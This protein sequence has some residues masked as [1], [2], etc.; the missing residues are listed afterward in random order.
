L[1]SRLLGRLV[2]V[3]HPA[4]IAAVGALFALSFDTV[5]Q[6]ALFSLAARSLSGWGFSTLLG[7]L[8]MLGMMTTDGVNGLWVAG[9]ARTRRPARPDRIA[10]DGSFHC[11][12]VAAG[13][14]LRTGAAVFSRYREPRAAARTAVRLRRDGNR[15]PEFCYRLAPGT[16]PG[17]RSARGRSAAHNEL[18]REAR[19]EHQP[20]DAAPLLAPYLPITS[21]KRTHCLPSKR[22]NCSA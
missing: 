15:R 6:V 22:D 19:I 2:Q 9:L 8:F 5:S 18:R 21:P 10:R 7:A 16:G 12:P 17:A 13:G 1:K 14:Q 20:V 4:L 11:R 3:S